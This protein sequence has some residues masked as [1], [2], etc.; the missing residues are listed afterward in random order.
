MRL[1]K[2]DHYFFKREDGNEFWK[3]GIYQS[4]EAPNLFTYIDTFA[5]KDV[6]AV[7]PIYLVIPG[8]EILESII[9]FKF[10]M[11]GETTCMNVEKDNH[12]DD[13]MAKQMIKG[14]NVR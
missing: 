12:C 6:N 8:N 7:A 14:W 10:S 9:E 13:A 4:L 2:D 1:K 5:G 11:T 3:F